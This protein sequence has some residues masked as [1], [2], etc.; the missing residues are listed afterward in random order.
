MTIDGRAVRGDA[1]RQVVLDAALELFAKQGFRA[2]SVRD[3]AARAGIT[4]PG[5]LY[6]FPTKEALLLA[7]LE[8]RDEVDCVEPSDGLIE[9]HDLDGRALLAHLVAGAA[10]NATKRGLVELFAN[11]SVESTAPDHPARPYFVDRYAS[12]RATL[13][14]GLEEL[15]DEHAL[16]PGVVPAIAAAHLIALMDGLQIQWLL[17]DQTDMAGALKHYVDGL[18]VDPLGAF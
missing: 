10:K 11:L 8:R 13:V 14:R 15:A 16:R 3:V 9:F 6:H 12:L 4:H 1:T 18:L 5:L 7:A 17:D 2:T